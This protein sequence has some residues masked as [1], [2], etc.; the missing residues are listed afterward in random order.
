MAEKLSP[1]T[2]KLMLE[3]ADKVAVTLIENSL[4]NDEFFSLVVVCPMK[5]NTI[6]GHPS[7]CSNFMDAAAVASVLR[8]LAEC[9]EGGYTATENRPTH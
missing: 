2:K 7:F 6:E 3:I 8:H 5:G 9:I 4:T 1:T